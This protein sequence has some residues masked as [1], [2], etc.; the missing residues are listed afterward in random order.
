[1]KRLII[2][3]IVVL[4]LLV[5]VSCAPPAPAPPPP[6]PTPTPAPHPRP[7]PTP[8]TPPPIEIE[9]RPEESIVVPQSQSGTVTIKVTSKSGE[10]VNVSVSTRRVP[11]G[12]EVEF[13]PNT[14]ALN[15]HETAEV[16]AILAVSSTAPPPKW[17]RWTPSPEGVPA[18]FSPPITQTAYYW[19]TFSL[20]C[21]LPVH[22][23]KKA[24]K[25]VQEERE[26]ST[27]LKLRF[28]EPPPLPPGM[29]TLKEAQDAVE[30]YIQ[31]PLYMPEDTEPPFIGLTVTP[32]EPHAV[33]VHYSTFQ[34]TQVPEPGVTGPSPDAM[35][36]RT[37][38]NK[39][40][41]L[42]GENRV[43]WWAYDIHY[44]VVSDQ[45]PVGEQIMIA[46]SMMLLAPG[47]G[48]WL[49]KE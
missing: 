44:S 20:N 3:L 30:F 47:T 9:I 49:R 43:D 4:F 13:Y 7:G 48:S 22:I 18:P 36:E 21:S 25:K 8:P 33:T 46:E 12:V 27:G 34:V 37:T 32:K 24:G 10:P 31:F 1:M 26:V 28:E 15:P 39:K 35:G 14:F 38:I 6:M 2:W 11:E 5:P 40:Q 16:E 42:I 17:P 45:V 23:D 29:V 19:V 41:V